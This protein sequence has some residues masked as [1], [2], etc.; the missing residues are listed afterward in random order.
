MSTKPQTFEVANFVTPTIPNAI[1]TVCCDANGK[2]TV[3]KR[4]GY[5]EMGGKIDEKAI[6]AAK[7]LVWQIS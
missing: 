2:F 4:I 3:T 1:A 7:Q 5:V 6:N